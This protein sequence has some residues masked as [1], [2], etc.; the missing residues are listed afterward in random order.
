MKNILFTIL[1]VSS[2]TGFS[3]V[4]MYTGFLGKQPIQLVTYSYS[5]G[6][7]RALYVYDKHDT[8]II[9]KW[10]HRGDTLRS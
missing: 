10:P 8:P 2:L 7:T 6:D 1:F 5:D 4:R 3:Q 9:I